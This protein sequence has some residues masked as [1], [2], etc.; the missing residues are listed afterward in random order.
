MQDWMALTGRGA[1]RGNDRDENARE[2]AGKESSSKA[3]EGRWV[4]VSRAPEPPKV[5]C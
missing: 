3:R 1:R 2:D 4:T 5:G